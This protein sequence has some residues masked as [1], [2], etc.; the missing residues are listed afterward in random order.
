MGMFGRSSG[1][2]YAFGFNGKRDEKEFANGVQDFGARMYD[3]KLGRFFTGDPKC[4]KYPN[5][6]PYIFG[7]NRPIDAIDY[8]GEGPRYPAIAEVFE[9]R[10]KQLKALGYKYSF[11]KY[12]QQDAANKIIFTVNLTMNGH[13]VSKRYE[14]N[15]ETDD[16]QYEKM[17]RE[18]GV[19]FYD[20]ACAASNSLAQRWYWRTHQGEYHYRKPE[21]GI[22]LLLKTAATVLTLGSNCSGR[23]YGLV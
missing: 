22:P 10:L 5:Y 16:G 9:Q 7:G 1:N 13:T 17:L 20:A 23:R 6:S 19:D 21:N 8:E 12:D 14:F 11:A 3:S 15:E 4:G 18:W 2:E